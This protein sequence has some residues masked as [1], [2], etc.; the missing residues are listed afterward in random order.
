MLIRT[1]IKITSA[2][3]GS[4]RTPNQVRRFERNDSTKDLKINLAQWNWALVEAMDALGMDSVDPSTIRFPTHISPPALELYI[5][6]WSH[7]G[8]ETQQEK[9]E[10]IRTG[11]HLTF[12]VLITRTKEPSSASQGNSRPPTVD[13][14]RRVMEFIG[15]RIGLSPW[16]SRMGYGRFQV[17]DV[18]KDI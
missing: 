13:E 8:K 4:E 18:G 14:Y 6:R 7:T 3:L 15:D 11:T 17:M 16:G 1:R 10:A 9:F 5:R 2:W 12:D